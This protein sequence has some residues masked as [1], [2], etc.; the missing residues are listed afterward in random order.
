MFDLHNKKPTP[1]RETSG[2]I[3]LENAGRDQPAEAC[4]Q[5]LRAVEQCDACCHLLPGVEDRQ[6]ISGSGVEGRLGDTQEEP[7]CDQSAE[8]LNERCAS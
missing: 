7:T 1:A 6:H 3:Q 5:N 2:A 8:V 4:S